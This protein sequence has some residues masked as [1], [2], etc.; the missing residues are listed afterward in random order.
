MHDAVRVLRISVGSL[1]NLH[2]TNL[3]WKLSLVEKGLATPSLLDTYTTERTPVVAEMLKMSSEL[4]VNFVKA[5]AIPADRE[6][7]WQRGEALRQLNVHCRWSPIVLD[8]RSPKD[9]APVDPYGRQHSPADIVRAGERAPDAPGLDVLLAAEDATASQQT[10]SLFN[11]FKVSHHTV[12]I[13]A[14][15]TDKVA[16]VTSALKAYPAEL[17][18]IVFICTNVSDSYASPGIGFLSVYDRDGHAHEG[19][20]VQKGNLTVVIVRPDGIIGGIVF[21]EDGVKRYFD[22]VLGT[23]GTR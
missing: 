15:G 5:K 7:A 22:K 9:I 2:Q 19:Y 3:S 1:L 20:H 10:T 14:D 13:F 11:I 18:R 23:M 4:F 21:G 17:L 8:E 6:A 16:G 12:L